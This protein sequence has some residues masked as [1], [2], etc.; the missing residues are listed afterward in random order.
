MIKEKVAEG[1]KTE[2]SKIPK[3]YLQKKIYK[4]ENCG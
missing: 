2:N 3:F 4:G 1:L